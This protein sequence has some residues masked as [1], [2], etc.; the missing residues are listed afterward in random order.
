M[1]LFPSASILEE[2]REKI[3]TS[4]KLARDVMKE[5]SEFT[6]TFMIGES[7]EA[8]WEVGELEAAAWGCISSLEGLGYCSP[9]SLWTFWSIHQ[10]T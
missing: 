10:S 3:F 9:L 5:N 6:S 8:S 1:V 7:L 4:L 2:L